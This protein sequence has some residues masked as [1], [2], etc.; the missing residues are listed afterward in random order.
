MT[1]SASTVTIVL[2]RSV[3]FSTS[4][5]TPPCLRSAYVSPSLRSG[6]RFFSECGLSTRFQHSLG[7]FWRSGSRVSIDY[8]V[9]WRLCFEHQPSLD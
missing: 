6:A 7:I 5:H 1:S 4:E 3:K 8:A 2:R 9:R